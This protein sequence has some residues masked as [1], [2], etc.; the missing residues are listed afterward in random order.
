MGGVEPPVKI[1]PE[2]PC[3]LITR[4]ARARNEYVGI[5]PELPRDG[6]AYT[7]KEARL[8]WPRLVR[9]RLPKK[10]HLYDVRAGKYLG[11]RSDLITWLKCGRA[12]LFALLP[13][14]VSQLIVRFDVKTQAA[15]AGE[16]VPIRISLQTRGG[17]EPGLHVF[18]LKFI[19][20][21]GSE[22]TYYRRNVRA[23][24]GRYQGVWNTALNEKTGKWKLD[25]TDVASG[26]T[27]RAVV[28]ITE[29]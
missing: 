4:F 14:E 5:L 23:E 9:I 19:G 21:D 13:Y 2:M 15:R 25:V 20:P 29:R 8:P 24:K 6:T 12:K 27:A 1:T 10:T 26:K 18:N 7:R 22:A 16:A 3:T 28:E 11:K 17:T